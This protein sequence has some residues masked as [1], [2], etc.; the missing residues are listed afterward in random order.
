MTLEERERMNWLCQQIEVEQDH[1]KFTQ[2]VSE[3]N[4]LLDEK[5]RRLTEKQKNSPP[6]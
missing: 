2:L 1:D 5:E 6:N 3:L 4:E